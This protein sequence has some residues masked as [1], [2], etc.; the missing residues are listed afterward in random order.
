M[1]RALPL[2]TVV[3]CLATLTARAED[4]KQYGLPVLTR[5]DFN[6][7]AARADSPVHWV[8]DRN[9]DG[10]VDPAEL[11]A[12][13]SGEPLQ[14]FVSGGKLTPR[15]ERLYRELV[16]LRRRESVARELDA[17]RPVLV[18]TDLSR[19]SPAERK[20]VKELVAAAALVDALYYR[21]MGSARLVPELRKAT[22]ADRALFARN[23]GPWC[24]TP[25][26]Q[27]DRHC[28]GLP[29]FPARRSE[30]YPGEA[31]M[32][33][34]GCKALAAHAQAK[35]L[36]DPFTVVRKR[37]GELVAVSS[38]EDP[39]FAPLMRQISRRL[40]SAAALVKADPGEQAL[41]RY[42]LAAAE[43]FATNSWEAADEAW[44]AMNAQNSKWYVRIGPDEVYVDPCQQKA[45]FHVSLARI[46]QE[47]L[48]WQQKL[49][50]LRERME[51]GLAAL[52]GP[53]YRARK[54]RFHMPDFIQMVLN[55]GDS[56]HPL[57]ATI[58]QSLPNW[59]KVAQEGRGRTVVMT[60][61]YGD[62]D[63]KRISR[64][65]ATSLFDRSTLAH[66]TDDPKAALVGTILHE[67]THNFGPY[68]DYRLGGKA[69]KEIFGGTLA[70]TLEELKA[71][72]GSLWLLP[73]LEKHKLL[74]AREVKQAYAAAILW[75]FGHISR[76][77][78]SP[79][80]HPQPYS[81]LAAVQVG[82]FL[83]E[84]AITYAAGLFRIHFDKLPA[85][86]ERLM[87]RV[88]R[89]KARGDVA[90]AKKL[91][92]EWILPAGQQRLHAMEIA[93]EM[94]KHPKATFRYGIRY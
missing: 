7:L 23:N 58:G 49:T 51:E 29:S 59:G 52:I 77:M 53:P 11:G 8:A 82:T 2:A 19:A 86:V 48:S 24:H 70:S 6:R 63:S 88:G 94:L 25:A 66:Y 91:I 17:G 32:D 90:G 44:A 69:P 4:P 78:F 10:L 89:I 60:N 26:T 56:R 36:L 42:L 34:A 3:V 15:F 54:V 75:A 43:G 39:R 57:G 81:Q 41:H 61:L 14:Q 21:Q 80:G 5:A 72:T 73:L 16:E 83:Q 31:E 79:S 67:A 40:K 30:T 74:T 28:N 46:D 37:N 9:A 68:S 50:P 84:G 38:H 1:P 12:A 33:D 35:R 65:Q 62:P 71:Q 47:S 45:G 55:A 87:Q 20:L 64:L 27:G 13:G 76:G 18:E 85:A 22:P 92:E 93:R